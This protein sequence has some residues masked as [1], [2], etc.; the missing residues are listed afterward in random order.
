MASRIF[1]FLFNTLIFIHFFKY[2][3]IETHSHAFLTLISYLYLGCVHWPEQLMYHH[4]FLL[5]LTYVIGKI[6]SKIVNRKSMI[7]IFH[8]DF[9]LFSRMIREM[10]IMMSNFFPKWTKTTSFPKFVTPISSLN[11]WNS[12]PILNS[13]K[14]QIFNVYSL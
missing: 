6:D 8:E 1:F 2:E 11:W 4:E 13:V 14:F 9:C 10:S 7:D 3:T 12:Y 5:D